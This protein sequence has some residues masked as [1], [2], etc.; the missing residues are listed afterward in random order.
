MMLKLCRLFAFY[1]ILQLNLCRY[2][3]TAEE[4][5]TYRKRLFFW[6]HEEVRTI[7]HLHFMPVAGNMIG[8]NLIFGSLSSRMP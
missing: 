1:F 4:A 7:Q 8:E 3:H 6:L 5:K 2:Q